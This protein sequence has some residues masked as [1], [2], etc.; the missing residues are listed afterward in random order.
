MSAEATAAVDVRGAGPGDLPA[1]AALFDGYRVFYGQPSDPARAGAFLDERLRRGDS[2]LLLAVDG[3]GA[4]LGF[5]QLYPS[6][7][8]VGTARIEILN[9][10]FVAAPA[11]GRGVAR[12]LLRKAAADARGRGAVKLVL[13]TAVDNR[14]A[15]ALYA[16]EGWERDSG[17]VEFAKVLP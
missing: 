6:F 8:S 3:Q 7:T 13:S 5:V 2:H 15:Q 16:A 1:L 12:A 9:D 11:R 14:P 10:L 4:A 17:F